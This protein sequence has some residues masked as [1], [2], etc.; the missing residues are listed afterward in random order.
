MV[1]GRNTVKRDEKIEQGMRITVAGVKKR[2]ERNQRGKDETGRYKTEQSKKKK[3]EEHR[4][5]R[6]G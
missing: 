1:D 4:D 5:Q 6:E 2:E 3:W